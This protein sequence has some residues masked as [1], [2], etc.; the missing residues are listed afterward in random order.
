MKIDSTTPSAASL[1][2]SRQQR[3][4]GPGPA[5]GT[6]V[7]SSTALSLSHAQST[8]S[9]GPPMDSL[10]I[11]EIRQSIADGKLQINAEKIADRLIESVREQLGKE[12]QR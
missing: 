5:A 9:A 6:S 1:S 4:A 7:E 8:E 2:K 11:A 3:P 10:R 12:R